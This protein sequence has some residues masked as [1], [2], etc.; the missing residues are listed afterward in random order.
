MLP[1]R[2]SKLT[3][4]ALVILFLI[5]IGYAY[6]EAQGLLYGP[7]IN[8]ADS[9]ATVTHE[10]YVLIQGQ[11][12]HLTSL[13]V[14]GEPISLTEAGGF[15]KPLVLAPGVNR[16]VFDA[17]DKYGHSTQKIVEM[18]YEAALAPSTAIPTGTSSDMR[19]YPASMGVA[20]S[21]ESAI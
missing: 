14:D 6:F 16:I 7:T 5:I 1:Y 18:V 21:L 2:D 12:D 15:Q 13:S 9:S 20:S 19:R 3:R 8:I 4:I 10:Q 11:A 17:K